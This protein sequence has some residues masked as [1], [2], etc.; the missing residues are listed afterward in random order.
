MESELKF[1]SD[2]TSAMFERDADVASAEN[3]T[4]YFVHFVHKF[5]YLLHRKKS[6]GIIF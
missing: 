5:P 4:G 1:S 3:F 6:D 2:F